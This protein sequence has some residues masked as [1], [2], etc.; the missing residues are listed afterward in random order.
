M[1]RTEVEVALSA[2]NQSLN[3]RRGKKARPSLNGRDPLWLC[4]LQAEAE[5]I[6]VWVKVNVSV[7]AWLEF[8]CLQMSEPVRKKRDT[9]MCGCAW[10]SEC[11]FSVPHC[12]DTVHM[13]HVSTL[14]YTA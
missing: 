12:I 5:R 4:L 13:F 7:C 14:Q 8:M 9:A 1:M 6:T 10:F 11:S 3:R 2:C